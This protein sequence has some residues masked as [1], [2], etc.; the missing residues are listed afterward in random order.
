MNS[1]IEE[2]SVD[3]E[4]K[5]FDSEL[6]SA[7]VNLVVPKNFKNLEL[8][9]EIFWI[10]INFST[11]ANHSLMNF[12]KGSMMIKTC[13]DI[14]FSDESEILIHNVFL[15]FFNDILLNLGIVAH[16]KYGG[17]NRWDEQRIVGEKHHGE[18]P[19]TY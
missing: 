14:V 18:N 3:F 17:R 2:R 15:F 13:I 5:L 12:F 16:G 10:M 7:M 1:A 9:E 11:I 8:M 19:G 4:S 6:I